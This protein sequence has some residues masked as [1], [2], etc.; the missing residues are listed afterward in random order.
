LHNLHD[1]GFTHIGAVDVV[2]YDSEWSNVLRS[3]WNAPLIIL[4]PQP[5][6][7]QVLEAFGGDTNAPVTHLERCAPSSKAGSVEFLH[8][9][10]NSR[11]APSGCTVGASTISVPGDSM[12]ELIS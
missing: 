9:D 7:V 8:E 3:V 11:M 1:A 5:S 10:T 2:F 6:W 12:R 4:E